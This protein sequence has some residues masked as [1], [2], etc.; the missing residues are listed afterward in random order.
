MR[1]SDSPYAVF[2]M[3]RSALGG[4]AC[5]TRPGDKGRIGLPGGKVNADEKPTDAL[6]RECLE[7]GWSP[8]DAAHFV[9]LHMGFVEGKMVWWYCLPQGK[10]LPRADF[11]EKGR[12]E[13]VSASLWAIARSGYGNLVPVIKFLI[14]CR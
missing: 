2:L 9:P 1:K 13:P 6:L 8:P 14:Y 5:T 3:A 12:V 11:K 10:L 4:I 7:E